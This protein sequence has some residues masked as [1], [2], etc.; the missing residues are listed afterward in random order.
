MK[1][2]LLFFTIYA[3]IGVASV[4]AQ[5][6]PDTMWFKYNDRFVANNF[7]SLVDVDS[8]EFIEMGP[9]LWKTSKTTGSAISTPKLYLK[10]G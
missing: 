6:C 5:E 9:T 1:K 7:V 10:D 4:F 2:S 3:F 8:V